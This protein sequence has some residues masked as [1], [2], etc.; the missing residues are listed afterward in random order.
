MYVQLL[1]PSAPDVV[2]QK[3]AANLTNQ[4]RS[5]AEV[6][7]AVAYGDLSRSVTLDVH[8]EMLDLRNTINSM[9]SRLL[10]VANKVIRVSHE[11][12]T[13]G[14][15]GGQAVVPSFEGIWKEMTDS[16]N[17]MVRSLMYLARG[18]DRG[19]GE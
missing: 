6:T 5:I 18:V 13:E 16:V 10:V 4:V 12:G 3:M 9:V 11:V 1:D 15:L 14:D 17:L 8:G 19:T 2:S 7:N